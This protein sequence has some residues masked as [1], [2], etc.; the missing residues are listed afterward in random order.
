MIKVLLALFVGLA[1]RRPVLEPGDAAPV[2]A[3]PRD[4]MDAR[5]QIVAIVAARRLL[6][7]RARAGAAAAAARALRAAVAVQ[8]ARAAR[9]WRSGAALLARVADADRLAYPPNALFL[10][11][12]G[13]VL[14]LLLHFSVAVSRLSDQ[15]KVLAQRLALL[16]EQAR[17]RR[18]GRGDDRHRREEAVRPRLGDRAPPSAR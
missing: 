4:L 7:V 11:A 15:T 13:F 8:R 3:E 12:F 10:I 5:I 17:A 6:L 9:C 16:E 14:V 18:S 1:R 2:A